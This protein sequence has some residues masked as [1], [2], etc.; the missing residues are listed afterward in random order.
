MML[1]AHHFREH[2]MPRL[3][4]LAR[5]EA[6]CIVQH[7]ETFSGACN[8]LMTYSRRYGA[9]YLPP[10]KLDDLEEWIAIQILT[11]VDALEASHGR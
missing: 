1:F 4:N 11:E 8:A 7:V 10:A 6:V 9:L 3:R 2:V 5:A